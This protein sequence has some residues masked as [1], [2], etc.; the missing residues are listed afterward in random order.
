M[1]LILHECGDEAALFVMAMQ[2]DLHL[3][4]ILAFQ[5]E[6]QYVRNVL[7]YWN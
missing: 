4:Q 3:S 1:P 5:T 2:N 7:L 6:R